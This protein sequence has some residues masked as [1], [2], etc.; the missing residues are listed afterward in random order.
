MAQLWDLTFLYL[1]LI[2]R[3]VCPKVETHA[4]CM[5][6]QLLSTEPRWLDEGRGLKYVFRQPF[7]RPV[8]AEHNGMVGAY[9]IQGK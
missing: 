6:D 4:I 9:S 8:P 1:L 7:S 3:N 2:V 5:M